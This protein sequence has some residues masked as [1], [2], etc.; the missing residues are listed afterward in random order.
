MSGHIAV[1]IK[2]ILHQLWILDVRDIFSCHNG[3][4]NSLRIKPT[5]WN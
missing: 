3:S 5:H 2:H 4:N 1:W